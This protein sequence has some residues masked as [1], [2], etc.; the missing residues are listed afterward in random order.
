MNS[1]G[2]A[3]LVTDITGDW[4]IAFVYEDEN[5]HKSFHD[6]NLAI[7]KKLEHLIESGDLSGKLG[8]TLVLYNEPELQISRIML[9]GLG[10]RNELTIAKFARGLMTGVRK[11]TV[12]EDV[13][14]SVLLDLDDTP[15]QTEDLIQTAALVTVVGA[16]GPAFH[17]E[18]PKRFALKDS[19]FFFFGD[20]KVDVDL[21]TAKG[22]IIGESINQAREFVDRPAAEVHP[23]SFAQAAELFAEN[24]NLECTVLS[25]EEMAE[26]QMYSFLAVAQGSD[27]EAKMI[28]LEHKGGKEDD[29][30]IAL[31]GKG[32]TFDSG[33]LS[34]KP[35]EYMLTMKCDMAGAATVFGTMLAISRL[36]LPVNV[37]GYMGMAE[38]MVSGNS[39][40]LGDIL[41]SRSGTTIEVLNTDAEGRLVL[42]DVLNYAVSQGADRLIDLATLTGACVVALGEEVTGL[43]TNHQEWSNQLKSA[44]AEV[45]ELVWELPMY[46]LFGDLL[47][48]DVADVK[49]VGPRWGGAITAAKFLE[50]FIDNHPWIH[51]DIAGPAFSSSEKPHRDAGATGC[52]IQTLVRLLENISSDVVIQVPH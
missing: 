41:S 38:N 23:V 46:D 13:V 1:N 22:L 37:T 27:I 20:T 47:E 8:E 15:V 24:C 43:F 35:N 10:K 52:M 34:L 30:T 45:G 18:K 26:E 16:Q 3:G 29:P 44:A 21:H 17:K 32:V 11:V 9:I 4:M 33:G 2:K 48:S 39:Y 50:K 51:L 14:L 5:T 25:E 49:N 19:E 31:V 28:I 40:K 6:L 7:D 42:A 36:N 12:K